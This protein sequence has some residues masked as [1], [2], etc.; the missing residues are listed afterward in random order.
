MKKVKKI[1]C[2]FLLL[3]VVIIISKKKEDG[4]REGNVRVSASIAREILGKPNFYGLEGPP[5]LFGYDLLGRHL[6]HLVQS[7]QP[8]RVI[9]RK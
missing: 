7:K 5:Y 3:V 9:N 1:G 8:L 6:A 2:N 4:D